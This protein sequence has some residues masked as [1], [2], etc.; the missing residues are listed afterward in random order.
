MTSSPNPSCLRDVRARAF[1]VVELLVAVSV[2]TLIV[3]V[4]Y[5][6]FDQVQKALRGNVAQVDVLEGGRAAM[7]L[8][9][10]EMEQM[11]PGKVP[12]STNLFISMT[13]PP[14]QQA[15]LDPGTNR[16]NLLDQVFFLSHLNK[17]WIGTGYRVLSLNSNGIPTALAENGAGTLCRYSFTN[18]SDA[19]FP[20]LAPPANAPNSPR[21]NLC[22]QVMNRVLMNGIVS[23]PLSN[24]T[25]YQP[26]LD[27]VV[28]FHVRAFD[29]N[30][31]LITN[32]F[33]TNIASGFQIWSNR[34]KND[35]EYAYTFT[36][37]ALPSV[38]EVEVG[39]LEPHVLERFKAFPDSNPTVASNYLARQAG[40]VHLFQQRIPVRTAK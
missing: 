10:K 29:R 16:L 15:M 25:N 26:V 4:L 12:G 14:Y 18:V 2:L 8:L 5:G 30:G 32:S 7:Q 17:T 35:L 33:N 20:N 38:L 40:A 21:T 27:G 13:A 37:Q 22:W 28:H 34:F 36:N 31:F 39:I 11:D 24:L 9:S 3:L 23:P 6:M 1:T 19:D